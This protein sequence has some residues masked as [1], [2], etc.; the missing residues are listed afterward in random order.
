MKF[1]AMNRSARA[2]LAAIL[3]AGLVPVAHAGGEPGLERWKER[4]STRV[5]ETMSYPRLIGRR[6]LPAGHTVV[7]AEIDRDGRVLSAEL[8]E[9]S[10]RPEFDRASRDFTERLTRLPALPD[11]IAGETVKLRMHLVYADNERELARHLKTV[12]RTRQL[13]DAGRRD[14][15]AQDAPL[16]IELFG[17]IR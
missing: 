11:S 6:D 4:A 15:S 10:G 5:S 13:A 9:G 7:E 8:V 3:F 14:G 17:G 12:V 1:L 2:A 16:Q